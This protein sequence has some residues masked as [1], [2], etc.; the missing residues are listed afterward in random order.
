MGLEKR[1][2]A[3]LLP[4]Y[5]R[6]RIMILAEAY[7]ELSN[8]FRDMEKEMPQKSMDRKEFMYRKGLQEN[9]K[10]MEL[11]LK[12][13]AERMEELAEESLSYSAPNSRKV[14]ILKNGLA[15]HGILLKDIFLIRRK[16]GMQFV[17]TMR[18]QRNADYI[19]EDIAQILT[20]MFGMPLVS[21][22]ENL[23]FIAYEYDTYLFE[24][25]GRYEFEAGVA[26][27]TKENEMISG[28]NCL[29]YEISGNQ[30]VCLISDG[31]GSG[32]EACRDS[33]RAIELVEKYMDIGFELSE[34]A[35]MVNSIFVSQGR[36]LNMP[37]LDACHVNLVE[38]K[39][40]FS[41]YGACDSFIKRGDKLE[42]IKNQS[43]PLGFRLRSFWDDDSE[44]AF[45]R[46][47]SSGAYDCE[48]ELGEDDCVLMFS[49]G[50]L[51]CF[52]D[53][54]ALLK[55]FTGM[56]EAKPRAI[57]NYLMQCAIR[58]CGGHI[59]DDMTILVGKLS[60]SGSCT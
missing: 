51:E 55:A 56:E 25:K 6:K 4:S 37:T 24:Y 35:D 20:E 36:D 21:A 8:S 38:G 31:A 1:E 27:A 60:A 13:M 14:R 41:K 11:R 16:S 22:K 17:L 54:K 50:V 19:A 46:I 48:Y 26:T 29:V 53:E 43:Y 28:D 49:D 5:G 18:G 15:K 34:A 10:I 23:F 7:R 45:E 32:E 47:G 12:E 40:S 33:E 52:S 59:R 3:K 57:A 9:Q 39:V 42:R 2:E 44:N 58:R 30:K